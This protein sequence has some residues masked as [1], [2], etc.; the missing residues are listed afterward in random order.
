MGFVAS[1][2]QRST[3][4][5]LIWPDARNAP[6]ICRRQHRLYFD[7]SFELLVQSLNC[8]HRARVR[9]WLGGRRIRV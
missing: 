8:I 3:L 6:N 7:P 1:V 9:H 4:R 2:C 5:M